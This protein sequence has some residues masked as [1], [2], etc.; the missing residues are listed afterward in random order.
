MQLDNE[1]KVKDLKYLLLN[2]LSPSNHSPWEPLQNDCQSQREWKTAR[3]QVLQTQQDQCIYEHTETVPACTGTV[4]DGIPVMRIEVDTNCHPIPEAVFNLDAFLFSQEKQKG[5]GC[6]S[7]ETCGG[8][9]SNWGRNIISRIYFMKKNS[10]LVDE[11]Y[12][13]SFTELKKKMTL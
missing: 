11:K 5:S 6:G 4:P 13:K 1:K 7:D 10:T 9:L 2:G 12:K 8:P 3:N